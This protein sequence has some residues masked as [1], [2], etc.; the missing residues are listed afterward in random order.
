MNSDKADGN[1]ASWNAKQAERVASVVRHRRIFDDLIRRESIV[2]ADQVFE[3][4][5]RDRPK[6]VDH[7]VAKR[8]IGDGRL[9]VVAK[10]RAG[11]APQIVAQNPCG[12]IGDAARA[13]VMT[14]EFDG[15][16]VRERN[17]YQNIDSPRALSESSFATNL[18]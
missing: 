15:D 12:A 3:L 6:T 14:T 17:A 7:L 10:A 11:R 8:R 18:S 9:D 13:W 2:R 1:F 4:E 16:P 5:T